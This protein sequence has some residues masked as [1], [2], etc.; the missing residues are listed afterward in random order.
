MLADL[1][2]PLLDFERRRWASTTLPLAWL[3]CGLDG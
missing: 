1:H 3:A 2:D